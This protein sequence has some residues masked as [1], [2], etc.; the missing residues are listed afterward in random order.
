MA[1]EL[2][3]RFPAPSDVGDLVQGNFI[4]QYFV[5]EFDPTTGAALP[6]PNTQVFT[7]TRELAPGRPSGSTNATIGGFNPQENNVIA[8]NGLQGV[9]ILPGAVGNQVLG[10]QIGIAG[11][12]LGGRFA[13][14]PN[15]ADG[16]LIASSSAVGSN[17]GSSSSNVI[18]GATAGAGNL[19]SANLGNGVHIIGAGAT[20]NQIE[21]NFIGTA[22]GGGIPVRPGQSGEFRERRPDR[23]CR[24]Q[25]HRRLEQCSSGTSS[26]P[27]RELA[28]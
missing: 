25:H 15:G 28:C 26:R 2:A 17:G 10:N 22:P 8:G 27:T 14:A 12:S 4:G 1:S 5:S 7:G 23:E 20:L 6:A 18:G 16:V 11:P 13:I 9:S 19:I 21:G 3:F 24:R